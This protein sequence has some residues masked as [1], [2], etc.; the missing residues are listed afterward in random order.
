MSRIDKE[1][2]INQLKQEISYAKATK[3]PQF[4][5]G[6]QR[7]KQIVEKQQPVRIE[8]LGI[9][10]MKIEDEVVNRISRYLDTP[11]A[12]WAIRDLIQPLVDELARMRR[13]L[14]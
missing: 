12:E 5:A 10:H 9:K 6:L 7:A 13:I 2:L 1:F 4:V 3:T 11:A 8:D 14:W